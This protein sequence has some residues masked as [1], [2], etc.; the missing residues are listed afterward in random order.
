M[1]CGS[2]LLGHPQWLVGSIVNAVLVLAALN[3]KKTAILP[4]ILLPSLAVLAQGL[5]FGSFT[6]LLIYLIPAV[7]IWNFLLV[8]GM[9]YFHLHKGLNKWLSLWIS[10]VLKVAMLFVFA[11]ILVSMWVL[12]ELFLT[13]MWAFQL[14]T[15]LAGGIAAIG[16]NYGIRKWSK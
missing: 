4:I 3:L 11:W 5:I 13:T 7:W 2:F 14:Y 16:L 12:P 6:F 10:G 15:V 9:K 1:F 8:W